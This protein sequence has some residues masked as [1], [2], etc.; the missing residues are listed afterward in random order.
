[1]SFIKAVLLAS[2][3]IGLAACDEKVDKTVDRGFDSKDLSQLKAG[4]WVDPTGCDHWIIDDGVEGYLSQRLAPDGR[5]VCSGVA[6]PNTAVGP[7]KSG[8]SVEDPI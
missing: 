4:I 6:P 2:V 7:F 5:P 3:A 8:S 1:M